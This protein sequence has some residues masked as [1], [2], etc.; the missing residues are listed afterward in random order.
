M[1]LISCIFFLNISIS[2]ASP[3]IPMTNPPKDQL[4]TTTILVETDE[5]VAKFKETLPSQ[6]KIRFTFQHLFKGYSIVGPTNYLNRW[7]ETQP[8]ITQTSPVLT[9]KVEEHANMDLIGVEQARH[10]GNKFGQRLTGKGIKVGVIDTG[11]DYDHR[12]LSRNYKKGVDFVDLDR[13]PLE[14]TARN[15]GPTYHGTHVA[16][17]I[18]ANGSMQGVAPNASLY[19]YRALG[20]GGAGTSDQVLAALEQAYIDKVDVVNLSLG[21]S[22]NAPDLP[23]TKALD[24]IV[25][26]GITAIVSSGNTG[27]GVWTVGT[28]G[29]SSKAITVGASTPKLKTP[30]LQWGDEQLHLLPVQ[31]AKTFEIGRSF[32]LVDAGQTITDIQQ[33]DLTGK[34][35]VVKRGGVSFLD[36]TRVSMEQGAIGI[37]FY[38][39]EPG[40]L[41]AGLEI[42]V[43]IASGALS[44]ENGD[45]LIKAIQDNGGQLLVRS[46]EVE[47]VDQLASFSSRGPVTR[48]YTIKPD[49]LAP[50]VQIKSTVPGGYLPLEGTSMSA[51]YV[52]GVAALLKEAHPEWGPVEIKSALMT[53]AEQLVD[54]EKNR[55]RVYEQGAGRIFVEKALEATSV[56][57]PTSLTFYEKE[58]KTIHITNNS[59]KQQ[60]YFVDAKEWSHI[61]AASPILTL[62]PGEEGDLVVS[63]KNNDVDNR[64]M[65]EGFISIREGIDDRSIPFLVIHQEPDYPRIQGFVAELNAGKLGYEVYLPGG[66]DSFSIALYDPGTLTFEKFVDWEKNVKPGLREKDI[67]FPTQSTEYGSYLFVLCVEKS[68]K[69]EFA[70]VLL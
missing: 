62:E 35:A 56:Y 50:G 36:K 59:E 39:S 67:I 14:A 63:L 46:G 58:N 38:N 45:R 17:I 68:G 19:I 25:E 23:I 29:T 27:P 57:E 16:G 43:P 28:P 34:V 3:S 70:G 22:V 47:T 10:F 33:T 69:T 15:Y 49:V 65:T 2:A 13:D 60:T 8:T 20:P 51:P 41:H 52:A 66:A 1:I 5:P 32:T 64:M 40:E 4:Q 7:A 9:Y 48:S 55:Y 21:S 12:D 31:Q 42:P 53:T 44:K 26:K 54:I 18:A 24:K 30:T 37:L 61:F 6:A 11:L